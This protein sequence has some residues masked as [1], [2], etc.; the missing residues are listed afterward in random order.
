MTETNPNIDF[1]TEI[2][3]EGKINISVPKLKAFIKSPSDYAPSKAPVFYNPVMELNRDLAVLALQTYQRTV[4][5]EISVCEPLA[6]CGIRG[7]RFATEVKGV[8]K[9]L[10]NDINEKA[11]ELARYNVQMNG[12]SKRVTVKNEDANF[13]LAH[14]GAPRKRFDAI[15]IDPFGSPVPY[16]DSAIRAL[17]NG[18]LLALTATDMAPLC[19][20]HPKACIRKYGGK[21]LRTEYCHELAVRLLAGCLATTAAKHDIG[22]SV[23]FSH[24]TNHYI[25]IYATTKYGAKKADESIKNMGYILHCFNCFHRETTKELFT[26][27]HSGKCSECGSKMSTA[28]PLW[29]DKIVDRDFCNLM[30]K[31]AERRVLKN[32][33]KI[34]KM[35]TLIKSETETPITYYVVDKLCDALNIPVPSVKRLVDALRKENF[36]ASLTHFNQKGIRTN[37]PAM[38]IKQILH[39]TIRAN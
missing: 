6:S 17:R 15:D 28:G 37:G 7:I 36:Q 12:L 2:V 18:G 29:L 1:P 38:K 39:E 35:L 33:G 26:I 25:R 14:Y 10:I 20:V 31:E 16:L 34:W 27:E 3:K 4:N 19:G 8:Q 9:V 32:K 5:H 24:S 13:L 30:E 21:P 23:V 22:I 11:S